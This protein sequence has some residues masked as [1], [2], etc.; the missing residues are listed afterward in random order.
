MILF[1][2]PKAWYAFI[3]LFFILIIWFSYIWS[4]TD[5]RNFWDQNT[6]KLAEWRNR[7]FLNRLWLIFAMLFI[8]VFI[9]LA[10]MRPSGNPR[11]KE[12]ERRGRD[13]VILLDVSK[14]MDARDLYPSRLERAKVEISETLVQMQGDRVALMVFAGNS[15]LKCPLTTDH[16][17]LKLALDEIST[18]TLSLGGTRMGDALRNLMSYLS[19]EEERRNRDI[20][21]ITDGEDHESYPVEAARALGEA[22]IRL[23]VIG[24][25]REQGERVPSGNEG[26]LE[27]KGEPVYSSL[28]SDTLRAMAAAT[29]EGK[30]LHVGTSSFDL[31]SIYKDLVSSA[32][33]SEVHKEE[34]YQYDEL[35]QLFLIP[36]LL[37]FIFLMIFRFRR[38]L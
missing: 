29:P 38:D 20:I 2:N 12:S 28:N 9:S 6:R 1:R 27:Y 5:A 36:V 33:K 18:N 30:Y 17:F 22:G 19:N 32:E 24:L 13:V 14:S 25:G 7:N 35:Y 34:H 8:L 31:T 16:G 26:Y 3:S 11:I 4:L 23:L 10:L 37:A 15:A 21:L